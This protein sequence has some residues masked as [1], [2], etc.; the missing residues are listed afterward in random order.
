[1]IFGIWAECCAERSRSNLFYYRALEVPTGQTKTV[2]WCR[3]S[4]RGKLIWGLGFGS[5]EGASQNGVLL[6]ELPTRQP[7]L[8]ETVGG[9]GGSNLK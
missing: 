5:S 6:S 1:M 3:D 9:S 2:S 8:G 7:K 4:R